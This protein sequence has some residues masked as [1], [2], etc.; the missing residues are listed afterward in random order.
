MCEGGVR[1]GGLA[2]E[3]GENGRVEPVLREHEV[4]KC[5]KTQS[6]FDGVAGDAFRRRRR[7]AR[8]RVEVIVGVRV[9]VGLRGGGGLRAAGLLFCAGA[10]ERA[11]RLCARR[12]QHVAEEALDA[13]QLLAR[14]AAELESRR[15]GL[16]PARLLRYLH[17]DVEV[18]ESAATAARFDACDAG[19]RKINVRLLKK[20]AALRHEQLALR[21]AE[22]GLQERRA[23]RRLD[24]R[25]ARARGAAEQW[26]GRERRLGEAREEHGHERRERVARRAG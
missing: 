22:R 3:R 25:A 23:A 13:F 19:A 12:Q 26:L 5:F 4:A 20:E 8:V 18:E 11:Q 10:G 14:D 6:R 2:F 21:R 17:L 15:L 7:R 24:V 1:Q 16:C 9:V